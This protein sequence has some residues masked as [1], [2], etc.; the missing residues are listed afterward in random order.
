MDKGHDRS[1]T[2]KNKDI[3][4]LLKFTSLVK[5]ERNCRVEQPITNCTPVDDWEGGKIDEEE[6][7]Y[8]RSLNQTI[9]Q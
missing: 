3:F 2:I 1:N 5:Q 9:K 4:L 8:W 7:D 6:L